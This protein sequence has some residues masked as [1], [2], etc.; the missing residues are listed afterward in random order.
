MSALMV[1][2]TMQ[3]SIMVQN[4]RKAWKVRKIYSIS[5]KRISSHVDDVPI[6]YYIVR[7]NAFG[8]NKSLMNPISIRNMEHQERI[9]NYK[10]SRARRVVE[11]AFGILAVLLRTINHKPETC[12]K[13]S[14]TCEILH[15][16]IRLRYPATHNNLM[17]SEEQNQN[18]IPGAWRNDKYFLPSRGLRDLVRTHRTLNRTSCSHRVDFVWPSGKLLDE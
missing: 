16:H 13:I 4:W 14:K 3:V 2:L 15:N 7:E 1:P 8:I 18:V 6:Q 17:D 12:R 11:N 5:L 10:L 9:F